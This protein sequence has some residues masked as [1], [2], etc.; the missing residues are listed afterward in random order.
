MEVLD[1]F[2]KHYKLCIGIIV[3]IIVLCIGVILF[4]PMIREK[5]KPTILEISIA[6]TTAKIEIDGKTYNNGAY[7]FEPG[8]YIYYQ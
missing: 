6:P 5:Q 1:F 7:T 8:S 3:G 4:V 2:D